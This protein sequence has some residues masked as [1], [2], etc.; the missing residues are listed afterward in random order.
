MDEIV[1]VRDIQEYNEDEIYASL[2]TGLFEP[3]KSAKK[4]VLKPNWVRDA[5]LERPG[6][7][8]YV[9]THP[10]VITAVLRKVLMLMPEGGRVSIIDGPEFSSSFEKILSYYPVSRWKEL[11]HEK[12]IEIELI[13]LRDEIWEDDGNVVTRR[14]KNAGDPRGSTQVDLSGI[15]SEFQGH[16]K[17]KNG[18]YGADSDISETNLAHNG[19]NN[20]YRVSRTVMECDVFINLP[21]LKTHKKSGITCCLKNL[22]GIN[23]YRNYLP[24]C[25]LGIKSEGGDQFYLSGA[26]QKIEGKLMPLVHQYIRTSPLLSKGFS[27]LMRLGKKVFGNNIETIRGGAWFGNDTIWRMILDINKVLFYAN[28]DGTL[29]SGNTANKKKYIAIV[30]AILCGEGNGPKIPDPKKMNY[31]IQGSNPAVTDAVCAEL[32]GFDYRKIPVI[33]N[34]F[35]ISKFPVVSSSEDDITVIFS[36]REFPLQAI[37]EGKKSLFIASNGWRGHIEK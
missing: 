32:M 23:T 13:D 20:L 1:F 7:W 17:S 22:V 11:A 19:K 10:A 2:E 26:K 15:S 28:P 18:Y 27:P 21:K 31:L 29:R 25:S 30:D 16:V 14:S 33:K 34:A 12:N 9:I 5:H 3:V 6:H 35:K 24:H 4:I 8:D 36:D 37:P